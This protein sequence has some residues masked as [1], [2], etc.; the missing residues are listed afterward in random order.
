MS[1]PLINDA[2]QFG[3]PPLFLEHW[4]SLPQQGALSNRRL[5]LGLDCADA[6]LGTRSLE[7]APAQNAPESGVQTNYQLPPITAPTGVR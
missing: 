3:K 1:A 5:D 6:T 2:L 7:K 4:R